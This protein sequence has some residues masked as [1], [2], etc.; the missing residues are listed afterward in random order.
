V[1]KK[2]ENRSISGKDM[3]QS[4]WLS[5]LAHRVYQQKVHHWPISVLVATFGRARIN[6]RKRNTPWSFG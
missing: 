6:K 2:F 4:M 3:D 1:K 5:F